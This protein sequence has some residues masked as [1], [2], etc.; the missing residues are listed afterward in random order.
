MKKHFITFLFFIYSILGV[1]QFI[2]DFSSRVLTN[3][4]I[5][6][7]NLEHFE[8]EVAFKRCLKIT[9][10][11]ISYL[12]ILSQAK[13]TVSWGLETNMGSS[14]SNSNYAKAYLTGGFSR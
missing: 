1:S 6:T 2:D 11:N 12:Y 10:T 14:P 3:I 4:A 13:K 9:I 7:D 5:C 8:G